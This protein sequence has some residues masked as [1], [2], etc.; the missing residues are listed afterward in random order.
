MD[1]WI[2]A[3]D[4]AFLAKAQQRIETFVKRAGILILAS[5]SSEIC[6]KWCNKGVW[7]ER[8]EVKLQGD[9]ESVIDSYNNAREIT[10]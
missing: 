7:M 10:A 4:S 5:H 9:I 1:E 3:G 6:R 2:V 8:G